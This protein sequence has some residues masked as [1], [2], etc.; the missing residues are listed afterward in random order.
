MKKLTIIFLVLMFG[1][2]IQASP[3]TNTAKRKVSVVVAASDSNASIRTTADFVCDGTADEIQINA[4]IASGSKVF[5]AEG[6]YTPAGPIVM[7]N[8]IT[9][10]G[11]G[12]GTLIK[13]P[14]RIES[15]LTSD[16]GVTD[17]TIEVADGSKFTVGQ[18][19][20]LTA[21]GLGG[22]DS[23]FFTIIDINSNTLTVDNQLGNN[24]T[25]AANALVANE[26]PVIRIGK[27]GIDAEIVSN[28]LIHN[29]RIDG[30]VSNRAGDEDV[31]GFRMAPINFEYDSVFICDSIVENIWMENCKSPGISVQRATGIT[32]TNCFADNCYEG[33]HP[34][35]SGQRMIFSKC[36]AKNC[37]VGFYFCAGT[38]YISIINSTFEDNGTGVLLGTNNKYFSIINNK[39]VDCSAIGIDTAS[40]TN[41]SGIMT[42]NTIFDTASESM[43]I[44]GDNHII[45]DN[46]IEKVSAGG[47]TNTITCGGASTNCIFT[48]NK[49][50]GIGGSGSTMRV[51]SSNIGWIIKDNTFSSGTGFNNQ[52]SS[53]GD[54]K[55]DG[56]IGYVTENSGLATGISTTD[57]IAHGCEATPTIVSVTPATAGVSDLNIAVDG[58]NIT[59]TFAG[60]GSENFFW[61]AKYR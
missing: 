18:V 37:T 45:S 13:K 5:L 29:L 46:Y 26:W 50:I 57:T 19:I 39:I 9:L 21:D 58:T 48:N 32:A 60:G 15:L 25:T 31:D 10:E 30:N 28:V 54:N 41:D 27:N 23:D 7:E 52:E 16:G 22:W 3:I 35:S 55:F 12:Y 11:A 42:H 2:S 33:Y 1:F 59:V 38:D 8:G 61:E 51:R 34:G 6:E 47:G 17:T 53:P 44:F 49:V 14:A 36:H 43:E 4:A 24:Y 56:N 20:R 40:S